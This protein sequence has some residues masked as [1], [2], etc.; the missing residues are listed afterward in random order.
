M[1][2]SHRPA[3]QHQWRLHSFKDPA[4][5]NSDDSAVKVHYICQT[6][7]EKLPRVGE[8]VSLKIDKQF[9][10]STASE[11]Q[12]RAEREARS[13]TCLGADAYMVS[14]D[15]SSGEVGPPSFLVRLGDVPEIDDF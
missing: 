6:Y 1:P 10:Y 7:V 8:Q 3:L 15:P 9:Q 14:E 12:N 4:M 13:E 11:A 5:T 2:L